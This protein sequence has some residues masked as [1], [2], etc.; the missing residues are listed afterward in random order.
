MV[1][2]SSEPPPIPSPQMDMRW[3][4]NTVQWGTRSEIHKDG[5]LTLAALNTG[6]YGEI[7]EFWEDRG[8]M[9]RGAFSPPGQIVAPI[10]GG[11]LRRKSDVWAD[12]AGALYE[13]GISRRWSSAESIP[14][15][16]CRHL[17]EDVEL[18]LCQISTELS[19]Q[20][21]IELEVV[22][23]WLQMMAY[24][25]H[26]VKLFLATETFDAARHFEVFRKRAMV[27]GG[28]LG[29]ESPGNVNRDILESS[30][31]WS[32]TSL[33]LHIL[34]GTFTRTVY[35]YLAV[36]GPTPVELLIG[37]RTAQDKSRH[38]AY[39]MHHL[40]YAID[41]VPGGERNFNSTL[42]TA[43]TIVDRD[44]ADSVMREAM[45]CAFGG[46]VRKMDEGMKIVARLRRDYVRDYLRCLDWIGINRR[47]TLSRS[48][49]DALGLVG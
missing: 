26:E 48:F 16:A 10:G 29:L 6:V 4:A 5:G 22:A 30:A 12:N 28:G 49:A 39:A 15:E 3:K 7:P 43:E 42:A 21:S 1:N 25:Y 2:E 36:Y 20:A 9:P 19:Q 34:R 35:R 38:I 14:W 44:D 27:N 23:G 41:H 11:H 46:G 24:G 17:H 31:G 33:L 45:A 18:A 32:E 40:K 13:E 37:R 47:P 8:R